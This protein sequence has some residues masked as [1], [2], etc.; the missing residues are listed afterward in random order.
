M[1]KRENKGWGKRFPDVRYSRVPGSE[2]EEA[3]ERR[4]WNWE[5]RKQRKPWPGAWGGGRE[6]RTAFR[7]C[8]QESV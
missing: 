8:R 5:G 4:H 7:G 2:G 1:R 6:G 3:K